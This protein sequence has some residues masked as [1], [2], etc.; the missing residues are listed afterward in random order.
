MSAMDTA[1]RV[2]AWAIAD[3]PGPAP[4]GDLIGA[5]ELAEPA[6][7]VRDTGIRLAVVSAARLRLAA[8]P[9]ADP[10]PVTPGVV[11]M[12]AAI[13]ARA[14]P[15]AAMLLRAVSPARSAYELVAR[16]SIVTAMIRRYRQP[17]DDTADPGTALLPAL[18]DA[19]SLTGLLDVPGP[20][21]PSRCDQVLDQMLG[22]ADGRNLVTL[23]LAVPP[24]TDEQ[25][26]W[27]GEL[28]NGM[29]S[30]DREWVLDVYETA[31][32]WYAEGHGCRARQAYQLLRRRPPNVAPAVPTA[33]W[34]QA[35][36]RVER[37]RP[38]LLR[39]RA[40]LTDYRLGLHLYWDV[41]RLG[42]MP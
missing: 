7:D 36:A 30:E 10:G 5:A 9:L 29:L 3:A 38:E 34:W 31:M 24:V 16:H 1:M 19:S 23:A 41:W 4:T 25:S 14:Q 39:R 18:R 6:E 37:T 12:A 20:A 35:L 22:H 26:R 8:P 21:G 33:V 40:G 13:G 2:L 32:S 11:I 17:P 15:T 42:G 28:L 27:R